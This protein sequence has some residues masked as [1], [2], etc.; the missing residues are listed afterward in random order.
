MPLTQPVSHVLTDDALLKCL[1][2]P[3][4]LEPSEIRARLAQARRYIDFDGTLTDEVTDRL[5]ETFCGKPLHAF[6]AEEP[7]VLQTWGS[8]G[9]RGAIATFLRRRPDLPQPLLIVAP[10]KVAVATRDLWFDPCELDPEFCGSHWVWKDLAAL[11]IT[12][13]IVYDDWRD[14]V[15]APGCEVITSF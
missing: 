12:S 9:S 10:T 7:F 2:W 13:G 11:G 3:Q 4:V 1:R 8:S 6:L 15:W 14:H 5:R